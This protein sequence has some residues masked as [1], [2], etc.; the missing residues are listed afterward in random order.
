MARQ[1][2]P[3]FFPQIDPADPEAFIV[4][5]T[6]WYRGFYRRIYHLRYNLASRVESTYN[7]FEPQLVPPETRFNEFLQ[8]RFWLRY[9]RLV[10]SAQ[11]DV[12]Q[13]IS[14]L[15]RVNIVIEQFSLLENG[16][17]APRIDPST[18][19]LSWYRVENLFHHHIPTD[20]AFEKMLRY[21]IFPDQ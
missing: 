17:I 2:T 10:K 1:P 8:S 5:A 12:E 19:Q 7:S 15:R 9:W 16:S 6:A 13:L 20:P 11:E 14:G 3:S 4:R 21:H 18:G